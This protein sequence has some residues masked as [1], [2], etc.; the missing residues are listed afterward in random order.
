VSGRVPAGVGAAYL[1]YASGA[2]IQANV[3]HRAYRFLIPGSS[4]GAGLPE[5][6]KYVDHTGHRRT[7]QLSRASYPACAQVSRPLLLN[8]PAA[9]RPPQTPLDKAIDLVNEARSL[10]QR[11]SPAC[12]DQSIPTPKLTLSEGSPGEAMLSVLGVLRRPP[13]RRELQLAARSRLAGLVD[14]PP[15][16]LTV[17]RRYAR[18]I[19]EPG[20]ITATI[21][22]GVG[23]E[24][25]PK[26]ALYPCLDAATREL[27]RLL[28][29]HPRAVQRLALKLQHGYKLGPQ[30]HGFHPWLNYEGAG[31]TG[32]PFDV[33][34]FSKNGLMIEGG[35][36][37]PPPRFD[38]SAPAKLS[39]LKYHWS[40]NGLV[41]DGVAT[42][43]LELAGRST[44]LGAL[45]GP[46]SAGTQG[47]AQPYRAT[48]PVIENTFS[49]TNL[50]ADA[51]SA[52][53]QTVI[54]R[55][56]NGRVLRV[57]RTPYSRGP[58][59]GRRLSAARAPR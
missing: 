48:V 49:I 8:T 11:T 43:T 37:E 30:T 28:P 15:A 9:A 6:L 50:P 33:K 22:V 38:P 5:R 40:V 39:K 52:A 29:G 47:F 13:T 42:V 57:I 54:W 46:G 24:S 21:V 26:S 44:H 19:N 2:S 7:Q 17:Y 53:H 4:A 10:A 41:P 51:N 36:L 31:G 58:R 56:A 23:E 1:A 20:G 55:A 59:D 16:V 27:T 35:G 18:I 34:N 25:L 12:G 45:G 32:G 14:G 3:N